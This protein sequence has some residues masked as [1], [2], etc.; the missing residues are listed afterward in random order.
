MLLPLCEF[1]PHCD[2]EPSKGRKEIIALCA[3]H[4]FSIIHSPFFN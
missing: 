2:E 3:I 4:S 1:R